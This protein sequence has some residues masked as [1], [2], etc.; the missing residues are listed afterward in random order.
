ME[1]RPRKRHKLSL[2]GSLLLFSKVKQSI[3]WFSSERLGKTAYLQPIVTSFRK[4]ANIVNFVNMQNLHFVFIFSLLHDWM[5]SVLLKIS[6]SFVESSLVHRS[7][8]RS[9]G[10]VFDCV[11]LPELTIFYTLQTKSKSQIH[12]CCTF[13]IFE[14]MIRF[15][16]HY[17]SLEIFYCLIGNFASGPL[18]FGIHQEMLTW[19]QI[20]FEIHIIQFVDDIVWLN[21]CCLDS[22]SMLGVVKSWHLMV[23]KFTFEGNFMFWDGVFFSNKVIQII[24]GGRSGGETGCTTRFQLSMFSCAVQ[25]CFLLFGYHNFYM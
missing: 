16:I 17:C 10:I 22:K 15:L 11:K 5:T 1:A 2:H 12:L 20:L 7:W 18:K 4:T 3:V 6:F 21:I 23:K 13:F 8:D 14:K 25:N 24:R 19:M 9:A